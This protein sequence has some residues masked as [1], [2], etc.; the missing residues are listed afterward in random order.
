MI[1][2]LVLAAQIVATPEISVDVF[3]IAGNPRLVEGLDWLNK[4]SDD[5]D[6]ERLLRPI[7]D[8]YAEQKRPFIL[9]DGGDCSIFGPAERKAS[10]IYRKYSGYDSMTQTVQSPGKPPKREVLERTESTET[11]SSTLYTQAPG[12]L[13]YMSVNY[14]WF[15]RDSKSDQFL[16]IQDLN[17]Y[18][19]MLKTDIAQDRIGIDHSLVI[20]RESLRATK[21]I[22]GPNFNGIGICAWGSADPAAPNLTSFPPPGVVN[23]YV[24][25][26]TGGKWALSFVDQIR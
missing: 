16:A 4:P 24:L 6:G 1:G 26:R 11:A 7:V 8:S 21:R 18:Q 22:L 2:A 15:N 17:S 25:S 14:Y 13:G 9:L 5:G 23:H 19:F 10:M 20:S 12:R 3:V